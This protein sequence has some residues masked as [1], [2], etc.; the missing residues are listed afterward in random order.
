MLWFKVI[1][2]DSSSAG[3]ILLHL[4]LHI[5]QTAWVAIYSLPWFK[6]ISGEFICRNALE[7]QIEWV[8]GY[9]QAQL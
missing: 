9:K 2:T 7:N 6:Q 4:F 3:F 5:E 1:L 8:N